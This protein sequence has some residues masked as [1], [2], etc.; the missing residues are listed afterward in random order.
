MNNQALKRI[1]APTCL[2]ALSLLGQTGCGLARRHNANANLPGPVA[3]GAQPDKILYQ[4]AI[5]EIERGRYDVGR[6]TLQTLLNT[7]PDS[8]FLAKS[9]LAIADS[10]YSEGGIAGLTQAEAEFKDFITFFPTSPEAPEAQFR[11]GMAH[12][13]LMG[14][15]DR[16]RTEARFAE[17]EFKEFLLKYPDSRLRPRAKGRLREVQEVLGESDYR[18]AEFYYLK[19]ANRAARSRFQEI[20]DNYPNYSKADSALWYLG[21]TMERL[22]APKEAATYYSALLTDHPLSPLASN[23]KGRLAALHQPIPHATRAMLARDR[24]DQSHRVHQDLFSKVTGV[25]GSTPDVSATRHG[26]VKLGE[27]PPGT[28]LANTSG[29]G[30]TGNSVSV[31]QVGD[32][33]LNTGK[34]VGANAAGGDTAA[35]TGTSATDPGKSAPDAQG[36]DKPQAQSGTTKPESDAATDVPPPK[37][38]GKFHFL[39]R[40][41]P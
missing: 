21:Q 10:Y 17:V 24:A 15:P 40:V 5:N 8:E 37:K 16:D 31:E 7:Y 26:P 4:R 22:R 11:I 41:I 38:K 36:K 34:P 9:K 20:A 6:L 14:K 29:S 3:A 27:K 28:V 19:Q 25:F 32:S 30:A 18:I 39:K 35:K 12:F 33:A 13:R 2:A 1:L 23:A